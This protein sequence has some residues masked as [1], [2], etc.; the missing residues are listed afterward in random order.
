MSSDTSGTS[1]HPTRTCL[2]RSRALRAS[3][4]CSGQTIRTGSLTATSTS[5]L[6]ASGG[7]NRACEL[8]SFTHTFQA[9]E[10]PRL[11]R[12]TVTE[13]PAGG[14]TYDSEAEVTFHDH[15]GRTLV[16]YVQHFSSEELRDA[17]ARGMPGALD[18]LATLIRERGQTT[19]GG[20]DAGGSAAGPG[21]R[22]E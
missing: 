1:T 20:S 21:P 10:R 15:A 2:M 14:P 16:T 8:Y 5:G 19:G 9:I 22:H 17:H 11:I 13:G 4:R 6:A 7:W 3:G 18:R 12:L